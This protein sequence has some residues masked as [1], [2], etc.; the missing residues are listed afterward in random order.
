MTLLQI[1]LLGFHL[2]IRSFLPVSGILLLLFALLGVLDV[3]LGYV[4]EVVICIV[5][6]FPLSSMLIGVSFK[7]MAHKK[8]N[9]NLKQIVGW[10]ILWRTSLLLGIIGGI[11]SLIPQYQQIN[12]LARGLFPLMLS[13]PILGF[14]ANYFL[15]KHSSKIK[16][17]KEEIVNQPIYNGQIYRLA[18]ISFVFS[19]A[20][21]G[22]IGSLIAIISGRKAL[23]LMNRY[24]TQVTGHFAAK[25]GYIA[26]WV[27]LCWWGAF[28]I[29]VILKRLFFI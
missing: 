9:L 3:E 7:R 19:L 2:W 24:E 28:F 18:I 27:G 8:Y 11:F 13:I 29:F 20:W 4:W 16:T 26:G 12:V 17:K 22:G 6:Y 14:I 15:R 5:I 1:I 25:F 23:K 21:L 10:R